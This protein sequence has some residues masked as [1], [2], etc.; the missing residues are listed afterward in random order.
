MV[1]LIVYDIVLFLL[2]IFFVLL[3]VTSRNM[4]EESKKTGSYTMSYRPR[5]LKVAF[6]VFVV[7]SFVVLFC[8]SS[9]AVVIE[10]TV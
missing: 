2:G 9:F 4:Y 3:T 6:W 7:I 5:E 10:T 8:A 1:N